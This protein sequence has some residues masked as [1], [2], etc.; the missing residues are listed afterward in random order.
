MALMAA[1]RQGNTYINIKVQN[2]SNPQWAFIVM[3]PFNSKIVYTYTAVPSI[4]SK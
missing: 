3:A 2:S 4:P 1:L